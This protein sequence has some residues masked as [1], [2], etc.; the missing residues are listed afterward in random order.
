RAFHRALESESRAMGIALPENITAEVARQNADKYITSQAYYDQARI[1]LQTVTSQ[2]TGG[3]MG[4]QRK[5]SDDQLR[6]IFNAGGYIETGAPGGRITR[7][8][9]EK[10]VG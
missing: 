7:D 9:Y 6:R 8:I 3:V 10:F 5:L 2:M 4:E 1:N